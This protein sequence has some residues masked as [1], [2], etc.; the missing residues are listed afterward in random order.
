MGVF[1]EGVGWRGGRRATW[2][3]PRSS[4]GK[5]SGLSGIPR[6]GV[7]A[8]RAGAGRGRWS[9]GNHARVGDGVGKALDRGSEL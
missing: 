3:K 4:G 2:N 5:K 6:E 7:C 9:P 8:I 1:L